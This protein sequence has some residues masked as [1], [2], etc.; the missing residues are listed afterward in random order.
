MK[1]D[2]IDR[3]SDKLI[4]MQER[5]DALLP[6]LRQ[7]LAETEKGIDNLL[8]AIQQGLFNVSAKKRMDELEAQKNDLEVGILQAELARP[9]YTKDEMVRWISQFKY[10][11][12]D[13]VDYQRQIIDIFV[14][15]IRLYDD[16]IIFTYNYKDGTETISLADIEAALGSDF[17]DGSP[18]AIYP[19]IMAFYRKLCCLK[20]GFAL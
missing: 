15:S 13:S 1:D 6:S 17:G 5:E 10:G 2:E 9:K 14:N 20:N 12:V 18:P 4:L 11:N 3:I 7:Q 8:N 16:K 19:A